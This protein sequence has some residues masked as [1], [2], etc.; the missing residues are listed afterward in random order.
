MA[1]NLPIEFFAQHNQVLAVTGQPLLCRVARVPDPCLLHEVEPGLVNDRSLLALRIGAEEACGAKDSFKPADKP[2]ILGA[3]LL[4]AKIVEHLCSTREEDRLVLLAD[5]E[6]GQ[7]DRN[8][9]VLTPRQAIA[10]MT[11]YLKE[12]LSVTAF[13]EQNARRGFLNGQ[14]TKDERAGGEAEILAGRASLQPHAFNGFQLPELLLC[15]RSEL[16][17]LKYAVGFLKAGGG[18]RAV[19]TYRN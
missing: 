19:R 8:Q 9:A 10:R 2:P 12:K 11:G 16:R 7:E 6:R 14:A 17:A 5:R 3:A 18:R 15:K 13:M 1:L 4:H